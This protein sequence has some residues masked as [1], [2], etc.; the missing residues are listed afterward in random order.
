M[1][2]L[3]EKLRRV[4]QELEAATIPGIVEYYASIQQRDD[5]ALPGRPVIVGG[6]AKAM[7]WV[8]RMISTGRKLRRVYT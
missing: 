5:P 2:D 3:A 8:N 7:K 4:A 1:R 6:L